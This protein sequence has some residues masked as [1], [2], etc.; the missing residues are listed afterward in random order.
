MRID[1]GSDLKGLGMTVEEFLACD[2]YTM[3]GDLFSRAIANTASRPCRWKIRCSI[4][5]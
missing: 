2:Q 5:R 4:W 1:D 3:Q